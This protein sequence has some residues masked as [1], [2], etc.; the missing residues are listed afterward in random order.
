[1]DGGSLTDVIDSNH[2][3]EAQIATI[4][5]ET[6]KGLHHLHTMNIIHRDIKSDNI[7]LG[8]GGEVK[9]STHP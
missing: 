9:L 2:I 3:G 7:L 4:M 5:L 8:T 1:M 6:A